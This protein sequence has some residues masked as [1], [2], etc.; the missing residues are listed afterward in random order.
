MALIL[1]ITFYWNILYRKF[2]ISLIGSPLKEHPAVPIG[3]LL[4]LDAY[5][6]NGEIPFERAILMLRRTLFP[7]MHDPCPWVEGIVFNEQY[8]CSGVCVSKFK[9]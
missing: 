1:C 6:N 9:M 3:D 4:W 7:F 2:Y 8:T 5:T